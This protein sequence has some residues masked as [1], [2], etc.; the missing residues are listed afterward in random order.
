MIGQQFLRLLSLVVDLHLADRAAAHHR[1]AQARPAAAQS[2]VAPCRRGR[3]DLPRAAR[4]LRGRATPRRRAVPGRSPQRP[5]ARLADLAGGHGGLQRLHAGPSRAPLWLGADPGPSPGPAVPPGGRLD[6][7]HQ[8]T[9]ALF[10]ALYRCRPPT[11]RGRCHRSTGSTRGP[12][13]RL[14]TDP[15]RRRQRRHRADPLADPRELLAAAWADYHDILGPLRPAHPR[16][17][18]FDWMSSGYGVRPAGVRGGLEAGGDL[19]R[20]D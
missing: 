17:P 16:A 14:R 7:S 11:R 1:G 9:H 12:P 6:P 20:D 3:P 8:V 4:G 13:S 5:G 18:H 2:P 19:R 10:V 15:R